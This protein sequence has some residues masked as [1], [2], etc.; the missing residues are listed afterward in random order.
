MPRPSGED[1]RDVDPGKRSPSNTVEAYVDVEHCG[2]TFRCLAGLRWCLVGVRGGRR[3]CLEDGTDR[4]EEDAHAER[5][6]HQGEFTTQGFNTEEDEDDGDD[7]L[8][9]T[10]IR[11]SGR[12]CAVVQV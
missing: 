7:D 4:E 2:H 1:I 12:V 6:D 11:F 9:N 5:G 3:V 10:W 8:D